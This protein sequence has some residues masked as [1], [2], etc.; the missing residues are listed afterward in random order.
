MKI[1][2]LLITSC[3]MTSS[4]FSYHSE[5]CETKTICLPEPCCEIPQPPSI[6][7]YNAPAR[8]NVCGSWDF[9]IQSSFI[10]WLTYEEGLY[11]GV[12]EYTGS[13]DLT[14]NPDKMIDYDYKFKPGFKVAIGG[15]SNY[16]DWG[17]I[18]R[19]VWYHFTIN[20][21]QFLAFVFIKMTI[22]H[23]IQF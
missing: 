8:I 14:N 10:Y 22:F 19:Y 7:A 17:A 2:S 11:I 15:N 16:D 12:R 18:L 5:N 13:T 9:F 4:I 3:L 21:F 1:K 20:N 6:K 23:F